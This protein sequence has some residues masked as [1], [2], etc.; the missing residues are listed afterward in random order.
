MPALVVATYR[1]DELTRNHP[2]RAVLGEFGARALRVSV[3]PLSP[4]AVAALAAESGIDA[5]A[6]YRRTNGN[7]FFVT[8]A[9]A[10]GGDG[11]P[12]TVRDAVLARAA[13][14]GDGARRLLDAV[15]VVP[16]R[17]ERPLLDRLVPNADVALD[18]CTT[19]GMLRAGRRA[20]RASATSW[21][22]SRSRTRFRRARGGRFTARCSRR[23]RRRRV[24]PARLAH[25]AEEAADVE[26]ILRFAPEAAERAAAVGAHREAAE[27]YARALRHAADVEPALRAG[28]AR[29]AR[30]LVLP[31]RPERRGARGAAPRGADLSRARRRRSPRDTR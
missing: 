9:L 14:L 29:A 16:P 3:A 27:Q 19:A 23:S 17:V 6:L 22:G 26:A 21:R 12:E 28:L 1:D 4:E 5:D 2:L 7:P 10:A 30:D 18:E 11:V 13:R 8:E 15:A 24:D 25:H 31:D 20:G